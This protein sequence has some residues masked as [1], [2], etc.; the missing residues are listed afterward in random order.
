M[1]SF[2]LLAV[3]IASLFM[4]PCFTPGCLAAVNFGTAGSNSQ[5][6]NPYITCRTMAKAEKTA[7]FKMTTK[8]KI[9]GYACRTYQAIKK[10]MIQV[11]WTKGDD[12]ILIRKALGKLDISGDYNEYTSRITVS[13]GKV[14]VTMKGEGDRYNVATWTAGKYSFAIDSDQSLSRKTMTKLVKATH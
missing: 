11:S 2:I 3:C 12:Q 1:K 13:A 10:E 8:K 14:K 7:G 4:R 6:P 9:N 5:I